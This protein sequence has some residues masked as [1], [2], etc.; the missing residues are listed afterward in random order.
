M[1][2]V[3]L[4][5]SE[6]RAAHGDAVTV[7]RWPFSENDRAIAEGDTRGGVKLII[8]KGAK[9]LGAHAA[10]A[11]ADDLIQIAGAVMARGGTV[12]D[13]TSAVAPYP[14]RGEVF[15]RAASKYYEPTVFGPL[16]R[17]LARLLTAFH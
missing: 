13:L 8:G 17:M 9:L 1:A 3:G 15:K 16:A 5:E 2:G 12:R 7:S 4:T 6:A 11:R 10:G 14:T